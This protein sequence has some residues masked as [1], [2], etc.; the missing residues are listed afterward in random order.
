MQLSLPLSKTGECKPKPACNI[1]MV[2]S[3]ALQLFSLASHS[4]HLRVSLLRLDG[5]PSSSVQRFYLGEK[6]FTRIG[7]SQGIYRCYSQE[8]HLLARKM[9]VNHKS[10]SRS[11]ILLLVEREIQPATKECATLNLAVH[12]HKHEWRERRGHTLDQGLV[13]RMRGMQELVPRHPPFP[14]IVCTGKRATSRI[15]KGTHA[16]GSKKH[17]RTNT[18]RLCRQE[19]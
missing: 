19:A 3:L 11:N 13:P 6:R 8:L 4:A 14:L 1:Q 16:H 7:R 12:E 10:E 17:H 18:N 2:Y 5:S 15:A 9:M